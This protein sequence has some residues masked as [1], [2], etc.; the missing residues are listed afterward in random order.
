MVATNFTKG[1][2]ARAVEAAR[3]TGF[4]LQAVEI[5]LPNGTK[6]RLLP[7]PLVS[8]TI[9]PIEIPANTPKSWD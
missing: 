2:I 9:Q 1:D 3:D 8:G 6:L 4:P 5:E 7:E